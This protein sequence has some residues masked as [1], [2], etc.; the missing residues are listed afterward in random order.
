[1]LNILNG[2]VITCCVIASISF[3]FLGNIPAMLWAMIALI[4]QIRV[5]VNDNR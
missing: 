2:I 1:M 3:L 5:T 4:I